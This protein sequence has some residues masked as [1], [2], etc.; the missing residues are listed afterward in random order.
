[1][2]TELKEAAEAMDQVTKLVARLAEVEAVLDVTKKLY[3]E[4]DELTLKLKEMVGIDYEVSSGDIVFK[5]VDNFAE[6]NTVFRPAGVRR[7]DLV[8]DSLSARMIK[9]MKKSNKK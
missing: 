5:V 8:T 3:A 7:F 1:M 6:K 9:E 2:S 4:R